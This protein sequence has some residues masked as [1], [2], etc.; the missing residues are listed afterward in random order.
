MTAKGTDKAIDGGDFAGAPRQGKTFGPDLDESFYERTLIEA[1]LDVRDRLGGGHTAVEDAERQGLTLDRLVLGA[2]VLGAKIKGLV[3]PGEP[4][5]VMLP[6]V[7]GAAVVFFACHTAG[8]TPAM[9]N[10]SSGVRDLT[11]CC[12]AAKLK[13]VISSR[14]FVALA[15]LEDQVAAL[16]KTVDMVWVEDLRE[17]ISTFEKLSGLV[18]AR[19]AR[20]YAMRSGET[21][22]DPAVILFTAGTE[23]VP[24]GVVLS[25]RNILGNCDQVMKI[26]L[27]RPSDV[28]FNALPIFHSFGLTAGFLLPVLCG[29]K[30]FLYPS[31]LHYKQIPAMVRDGGGTILLATDT[32]AQGWGRAADPDDFKGVRFPVLGAERVKAQT[33]QMWRDKFGI[34]L[35]EG[36]GVTETSPVL[37][38]NT[39]EHFREGT[40]GRLLP[41]MEYRLEPV[42]GLTGAGRLLIRGVNVMSGYIL[43][44][45]PGEIQP[46]AEGWHDTGD[47][48][49]ID[50]EGF[51]SI[52]GRAKRFAKIG[53]EMVSLAAV[54]AYVAEVWPQESHAVIAVQDERKGEQLVLVTD[55]AEA[56][57]EELLRW[58]KE[59]G[60]SELHLPRRI[61]PVEGLPVMGTGKLDYVAVN[62]LVRRRVAA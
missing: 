10:F 44:D 37:G 28:I 16:E 33:R 15:G 57:R 18:R 46:P 24:K 22:G 53:G 27:L 54:E 3:A 38:V 61:I 34:Q 23:G 58:A 59:R 42:A 19:L 45:R 56:D 52:R 32:F 8:R 26:D 11:A 13:R 36:Y 39:V 6:N 17:G 4:I 2:T 14:K 25:H 41:G 1:L 51:V 9:L 21:P 35:H 49:S 60:L 55:R 31:P 48:V 20:R 62:D 43:H 40:I 50:E 5:G 29:M 7:N 30:S 47:I 12:K